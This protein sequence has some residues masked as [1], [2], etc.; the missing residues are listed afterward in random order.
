MDIQTRKI[1]FIQKFLNL[2]NEELIA[3]FE[4]LIE[5][6]SAKKR[7]TPVPVPMSI[8]EFDNRIKQSLLDSENHKLTEAND[9]LA[10]IE[11]WG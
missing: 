6:R 10:E 3:V 5:E 8:E 2:Q 9:L 1:N 4:K 11:K 7:D